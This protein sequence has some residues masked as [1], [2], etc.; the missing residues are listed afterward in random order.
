MVQNQLNARSLL[1][2]GGSGFVGQS[3]NS[4]L[5]EELDGSLKFQ[6]VYFAS[7]NPTTTT[8]P[9]ARSLRVDLTSDQLSIPEVDVIL[10]AATPASAELNTY[11]PTEMYSLNVSVMSRLLDTLRSW[12]KPPLVIFTSSGAVYGEMPQDA[13]SFIEGQGRLAMKQTNIS[14]YAEGKRAAEAM[15]QEATGS[16]LCKGITT[17][18]FAFSGKHLPRDRHFAIGNFVQ[19]SVTMKKVVVRSDGSSVRSYL[20]ERD[21]AHWLLSICQNGTS[22]QIYHIGSERAISI[23]ELAFLVAERC[24]LMTGEKIPVEILGKSSPLDGVSRYVPS[25]IQTR[26][27][28]GL[29]ETISLESSIDSMLQAAISQHS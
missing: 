6:V 2:L 21:M 29:S 13:T 22:D 3:I 20:D 5:A 28:L 1:L 15:L 12:S 17:R 7:R 9:W 26:E 18:L 4:F 14:A 24:E 8:Q 10:H 11:S 25:T 19:S 16:G 23:R 27:K